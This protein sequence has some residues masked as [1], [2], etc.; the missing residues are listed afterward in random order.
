MI[1][2]LLMLAVIVVVTAAIGFVIG[3]LIAPRLMRSIDR[4]ER[5]DDEP[6]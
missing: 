2:D 1:G 3:K 4:E 5:D 6:R